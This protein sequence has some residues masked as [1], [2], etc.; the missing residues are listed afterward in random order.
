MRVLAR[1]ATTSMVLPPYSESTIVASAVVRSPGTIGARCGWMST[2][3]LR[4]RTATRAAEGGRLQRRA[5]EDLA[6]ARPASCRLARRPAGCDM[7][8]NAATY[9]VAGRSKT[10]SGVSYCSMRPLRMMASRSP[11]ASASDWSWVTN[12]AVKPRRPWSS[13]ISAR[14]WSRRRA[15]RLLSGSSN[16]TRSGRAT[17]PRA[18]ATRCCWPPLSCAGIAV[19]ERAAVDEG[20]GLLDPSALDALLDAASLERV[21]DVLADGHVRPQRVRLEHHADVALVGRQVDPAVGVEHRGR[22]EADLAGARRFQA[23]EAAQRGRLAAPARTEEDEE[24]ALLDLEVQV[25]DGL[26]SAACRRSAW[27]VE[28]M[29]TW[30]TWS[31]HFELVTVVGPVDGST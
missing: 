18:S 13:W 14:T 29:L 5:A 25:V 21:A 4:R 27:S 24:L 26:W 23:G 11:R 6:V 28:W 22:A 1:R 19:E 12:T 31:P 2:S 10:R 17:R 3:S 30:D 7:P 16:S 8:M 15:S 20:G 9:S